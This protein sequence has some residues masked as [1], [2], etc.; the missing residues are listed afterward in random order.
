MGPEDGAERVILMRR[1]FFNAGSLWV[2]ACGIVWIMGLH[3]S[4]SM[5]VALILGLFGTQF[6]EAVRESVTPKLLVDKLAKW[7]LGG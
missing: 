2:I 5:V 6:L 3:F 1:N 4:V 7:W